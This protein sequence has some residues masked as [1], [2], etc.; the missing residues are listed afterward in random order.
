[1]E[2]QISVDERAV[3]GKKTKRLRSA[4][5]VPA[6]LFGKKAGSVSVQLDAKA[7]EA[8]YR[9]AGRTSIVRVSV[10]GGA[11]TSVVIKSVQ[12]HPLTGRALHVDFFAPDLTQEMAADI[13]IQFRGEAPA[14]EATGGYLLTSL[15][16]LKVKALPADLPHEIV[17]DI[18]PLVDLEA[19]IHVSDLVV[20][21]KVTVLNEPDE[22]VARVMPPRVEEEPEIEVEA[23]E[24]E[25]GAEGEDGEAAEGAAEGGEQEREDAS[26]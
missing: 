13:P 11:P 1:M 24:G 12:R 7:F 8:L 2:L 5:I 16:H 26:E 23:E 18:S 17:V 25:E 21:E 9:E 3:S 15:D 20:D 22:M 19:A 10:N 6:V 14:V 4:G